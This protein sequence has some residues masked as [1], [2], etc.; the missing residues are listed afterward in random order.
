[1]AVVFRFVTVSRTLHTS[2]PSASDEIHLEK[3]IGANKDDANFSVMETPQR[4]GSR[5]ARSQ[6]KSS[7]NLANRQG[8]SSRTE[9]RSSGK[10]SEAYASQLV[11]FVSNGVIESETV[12]TD[13]VESK[14]DSNKV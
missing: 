13:A 10:K 2:I 6:S 11:A 14:D 8:S 3:L 1:M 5:S 4:S 9:K 12:K 7:K